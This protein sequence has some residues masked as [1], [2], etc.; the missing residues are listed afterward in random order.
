M[1]INSGHF[2]IAQFG[3]FDVKNYGDL[4]FPL[5]AQNELSKFSNYKIHAVSPL[6]MEHHDIV[7]C[8]SCLSINDVIES[9]SNYQGVLIGG[10]NILHCLQTKLK[11]YGVDGKSLLAYSDLW[12]G[13][14]FF[15]PDNVPVVWNAPGVPGPFNKVNQGLIKSALERANYLSVR[16]EMS[17][18]YLLDVSPDF[19]IDVVPD[20][21][22]AV[23]ELWTHEQLHTT[24]ESIFSKNGFNKPER[25][26]VFHLNKRYLGKNTLSEM[27]KQLDSI[28]NIL[29]AQPILIAIGQCHQDDVIAREVAKEM[30][31]NPILLDNPNTLQ[32]I[33][34]CI[35]FADAYIGS[36]MHGLI[37]ACAFGVPGINVANTN[38]AKFVGLKDIFESEGI[39]TSEWGT[40]EEIIT[41]LDFDARKEKLNF[42]HK[43]VLDKLK[44]HWERIHNEFSLT[45]VGG[46]V[47][48]SSTWKRT[49]DY[50]AI[51][52]ENLLLV[53]E[54]RYNEQQKEKIMNEK[55]LI[56]EQKKNLKVISRLQEELKK[57]QIRTKQMEKSISW[58]LTRPLRVLSRRYPLAGN[59]FMLLL[60]NVRNF[61]KLKNKNAENVEKFNKVILTLP[62]NLLNEIRTYN[63]VSA[64][65][66][67]KIVVYTAIYGDY[68][69][70][71]LPD[72]I[73]SNIDYICFTDRPRNTYGVWKFKSSPYYH[74]DPTRSA[75]FVKTHP[76]ELLPDY[77]FA[78]WVDGNVSL[79]ADVNK[80]IDKVKLAE[81][82]LGLV[83]HPLRNCF[84]DEADACIQRSKDTQSII[85][86]QVAYYKDLGIKPKSGVYETNFMVIPLNDHKTKVLFDLWWK[87]IESFS[88]R[89]QL[90]LCYVLDNTEINITHL[91][92][93]GISVREDDDFFY[94]TH[95]E[96]KNLQMPSEL[97]AIGRVK[98]PF[99]FDKF[100]NVKEE[101]LKSLKDYP[102][103]II[104]CVYN[105]L[106]D[107]RLCLDSVAKY[108][109]KSH[110][111]IIVNDCS[112]QETTLYLREF[113]STHIGIQLLE[114]EENLGYT[115][116]ANKG[117]AAGVTEFR[118][119]LNSDTIVS[120]NWSLKLLDVAL[121]DE[122]IGIV[123]PLSNAAGVQSV[124]EIKSTSTNTAINILP[125]NIS[126]ELLDEFLEKESPASVFPRLSLIH[127][128]CFGIKKSVIDSIGY[129]DNEN[130]ARYYGEENDY[131]FRAKRAGFDFAVATNTFVYHR[132]SRSIVE[133][134]RIVHMGKAGKR[135]RELY[136]KEKVREACLV[137]ENH[138]ILKSIRVRVDEF[139]SVTT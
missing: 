8:M 92:P 24:R 22:W 16:D 2:N 35:A 33:V 13:P 97:E 137:G 58:K 111:L 102:I 90:A 49:S 104:I 138:P 19:E 52:T 139:F 21:A 129:F 112:D 91:L 136:G 127:G 107:V 23:N 50:R 39:L 120:D 122:N 54:A 38:M 68:D 130:F 14:N 1:K 12:I 101:R 100:I 5:L 4:L 53:H 56:H 113:A 48:T 121:Q 3:T 98:D 26:V 89:D 93:S 86:E 45:Q 28:A 57:E 84:Y 83:P 66:R 116:S 103:D 18:Q 15:F 124:P 79:R 59:Q 95:H 51:A 110:R 32:E 25:T 55:S 6:G 9:S 41:N 125:D 114:N 63:E 37:T 60:N 44:V 134:E 96:C 30:S 47:K 99:D 31:A 108:M 82:S 115:Q 118:V 70:L 36:S 42:L 87:Q 117:L 88:R 106:E 20:T 7:D 67:K 119:I 34:A 64:S 133:E 80:Y 126:I 73:D 105:A 43:T 75:R 65:K 62:D 132:K 29:S 61:V 109:L 76:H 74:Q 135:L 46:D 78:V 27:A 123:G 10:G 81:T 94:L 72:V 71:L 11:D 128:F 40:A 131:C 77:E 69:T 85:K 17:K